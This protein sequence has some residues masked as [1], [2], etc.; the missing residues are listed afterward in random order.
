M[1]AVVWLRLSALSFAAAL[2]LAAFVLPPA[3]WRVLLGIVGGCVGCVALLV[4][5]R[6]EV[7][8]G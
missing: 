5:W 4:E 2:G 8:H 1:H 7:S 3:A 6:E